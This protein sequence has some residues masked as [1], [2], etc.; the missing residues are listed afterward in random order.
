MN[1]AWGYAVSFH[2][3]NRFPMKFNWILHLM[4]D[5]FCKQISIR[6][7]IDFSFIFERFLIDFWLIFQRFS[8]HFPF[9]FRSFSIEFCTRSEIRKKKRS[10][11]IFIVAPCNFLGDHCVFFGE[12]GVCAAV[13]CSQHSKRDF[14]ATVSCSQHSKRDFLGVLSRPWVVASTLNAI[15]WAICSCGRSCSQ[16]GFQNKSGVVAGPFFWKKS[17]SQDGF[18]NKFGVVA[19]IF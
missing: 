3:P 18:Q 11:K 9:N 8:F 12:R 17:C 6:F 7:L 13:S 19:G 14:C 1:G 4:L 15:F 5:Q 10:T 2:F 16:D